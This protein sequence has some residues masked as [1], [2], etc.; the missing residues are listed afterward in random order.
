MQGCGNDYIY[1]DC[2]GNAELE[3]YAAGIA[4]KLADRHFGIGGDGVI[5]ICSS[6]IADCKIRIF[7]ADGSEAEM[8]GNGIRCVAKFVGGGTVRAETRAGVKTVR[9]AGG[10]YRVDMGTARIN[11]DT[12]DIGNPHKVFFAEDVDG[13]DIADLARGLEGYNVEFAEIIGANEIKMR[14]WERGSGETLS[15]GTGA[16]A[17]AVAA[18]A[19]GLADGAQPITVKLRGGELTVELD[20]TERPLPLGILHKTHKTRPAVGRE[21]GLAVK[22][23]NAGWAV[24]VTLTG[25]AVTVFSGV[26]IA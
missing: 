11:G 22:H 2:R 23:P 26:V 4:E 8:C 10:Q 16:C 5:L 25:G 3:K 21:H 9:R 12:V 19:R 24:G 7:N 17:A 20:R 14:V 15:C 18:A 6:S 13:I 1:I